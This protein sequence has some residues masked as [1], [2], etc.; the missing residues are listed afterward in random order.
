MKVDPAPGGWLVTCDTCARAA[1]ARTTDGVR[2]IER[3]HRC[4]PAD[5]STIT[6]R[7]SVAILAT[8]TPDH[9]DVTLD[10]RRT[11]NGEEQ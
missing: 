4:T 3:A 11:L 1:L 2:L 9:L 7:R 5:V 10:R 6:R 8:L